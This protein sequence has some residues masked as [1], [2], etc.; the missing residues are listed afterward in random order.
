MSKV[1]TSELHYIAKKLFMFVC[2][3]RIVLESINFIGTFTSGGRTSLRYYGNCHFFKA[4]SRDFDQSQLGIRH[5]KPFTETGKYKFYKREF[6]ISRENLWYF[7]MYQHDIPRSFIKT[8][9]NL[10]LKNK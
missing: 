1:R 9:A 4:R 10:H 6:G 7:S 3:L 5:F 2:C 8:K